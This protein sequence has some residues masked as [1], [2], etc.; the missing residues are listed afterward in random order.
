LARVAILDDHITP[1]RIPIFERLSADP[2]VQLRVLYCTK[3]L[4]E[5]EWEIDPRQ[6]RYDHAILPGVVLYSMKQTYHEP[7]S[8]LLNP[9]LFPALVACNPDV[10]IG[11]A[12]SMPALIALT[13]A[14]LFRKR[15]IS[16]ST[17]TL[18]SEH[19][20]SRTQK[21]LRRTIIGQ[22]NACLTASNQG[23]ENYLSYGAERS[24]IR[25]VLQ[26]PSSTF[27]EACRQARASQSTYARKQNLPGKV[28]LYVGSLSERK[29]VT[30]LLEAFIRLRQARADVTLLFVGSG[31]LKH[32]LVARAAECGLNDCVHFAGF[33]QPPE[34]PEVYAGAD[35][36][37]FPTVEDNFGVVLAEAAGAGL[38]LVSTP[39]AGATEHC[40]IPGVNGYVADPADPEALCRAIHQVLS[41]PVPGEMGAASL[42]LAEKN[43]VDLSARQI[44]E[45]VDIALQDAYRPAHQGLPT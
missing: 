20:Y 39:Y 44:A 32:S 30:H 26:S 43:N 3:R 16:W 12:F 40:V 9:T 15:F 31:P 27:R 2:S 29:G 34:L 22:A 35:V 41:H 45:A 8:I 23:L 4:R 21:F 18:R 13:Y 36:F 5:R 7:R 24:Q 28:I 14:R 33:I 37:V 19:A 42:A 25:V 10:V 38:P 6:L 11:Y 1:Y 17:G